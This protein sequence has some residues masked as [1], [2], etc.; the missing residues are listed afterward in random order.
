M[1]DGLFTAVVSTI[2]MLALAGWLWSSKNI[3]FKAVGLLCGL[4]ALSMALQ[5]PV[6]VGLA[7][8]AAL[9]Y[10]FGRMKF[11]WGRKSEK[12]RDCEHEAHAR[13]RCR[14]RFCRCD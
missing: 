11:G 1:F 3:M 7:A 4:L 9:A 5:S 10:L 8:L 14:N 12:C 13:A 6:L 2:L